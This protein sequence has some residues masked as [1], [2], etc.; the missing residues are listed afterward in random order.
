[1]ARKPCAR[2]GCDR[3]VVDCPARLKKRK[4]CCTSCGVR[5]NRHGNK[6][7][8]HKLAP[9]DPWEKVAP[10]MDCRAAVRSAEIVSLMAEERS[11]GHVEL[12]PSDTVEELA[13][14]LGTEMIGE[15]GAA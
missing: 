8:E 9:G 12:P 7:V 3:D 10:R 5:V 4:Y 1:M 15:R 2:P 6:T 11:R 13:R 14:F